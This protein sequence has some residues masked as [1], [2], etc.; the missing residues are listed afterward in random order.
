MIQQ[1]WTW[2]AGVGLAV[3]LLGVLMGLSPAGLALE[4]QFG[5]D[6]LFRVRGPR[7]APPEV[8]VITID[9][10]SAD[11]FQL[12]NE[13]RK[14][15]RHLHAQLV[16]NLTRAGA[17]AVGF[18]IHF[19]ESRDP[20]QD[21]Q[22]AQAIQ[23]A[24]NVVLFEHLQKEAQ[25][26]AG[27]AGEVFG[28]MVAERRIP[29]I[30]S[31][32]QAAVTTAPFPLPKVPVKV[33]QFWLFKGGAGDA[34]TLPTVMFQ[35]YALPIYADLLRIL[36]S[37]T[38]E[39]QALPPDVDTLRRNRDLP[40]VMEQLRWLFQK[41]AIREQ[42]A[43][44]LA[45]DRTLAPR[46]R[47]LLTALLHVYRDQSSRY[48]NYYGP[49]RSLTTLPYHQVW[50]AVGDPVHP[51]P[52][53]HGKLVLVGF[54][55]RLQ[56]E[57][58]DGFYTVYSQEQS[59]LDISGVEIAATALANM[60][61]DH[62]VRPLDSRWMVVLL[63]G[64]GL[65][66]GLAVSA[67]R[68]RWGLSALMIAGVVWFVVAVH[69]FSVQALWLPLMVPLVLQAP[70]AGV[71]AL[72]WRYRALGRERNRIRAAFRHYLPERAVAAL[73]RDLR[74][75]P[76]GELLYG[77][78]LATD[79][80][81]YTGLAERLPPAELAALLNR[82]YEALFA[83]VRR[84]GG[85]VSDVVGDAMLAIWAHA[86]PEVA[87]RAQACQ[88]ALDVAL[89]AEQFRMAPDSGGL[90]TRI[91][92]HAGQ[93]LLGNVGTTDHVEYRAVGDIVNTAS[94]LQDLN[95]IL[96][97][98]VLASRETVDGLDQFLRRDVGVFRLPGKSNPTAVLELRGL[99]GTATDTGRA[100][101]EDFAA[102]R[103]EFSAGRFQEARTGFAHCLERDPEDGPARYYL[104]LTERFLVIPPATG[105]DGILAVS[106]LQSSPVV[107]SS[108][109]H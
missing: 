8:V 109:R 98:R 77:V 102:A 95:K 82:Y 41:P 17:A 86:T 103:R 57:Q 78:C 81:R 72:L 27:S 74:A 14:W 83:P 68:L 39:A 56:P 32:A 25:P 12:P 33:S 18:D 94:R 2:S 42:F 55:E 54:S 90:G 89:A 100:L 85:F 53:L 43:T 70:L 50:Q 92:L 108:N 75:A 79:A 105:W 97:T 37:V 19:A 49:P 48:L 101:L 31:L 104:A 58:K 20:V 38:P 11:Y 61:A 96:G 60:I 88:A 84:H 76:G 65:V 73:A 29:P 35:L 5:L 63:F 67:R 10:E 106:D 34:A 7:P 22:F 9:K 80:A 91:G 16:D 3:G 28:E 30:P 44:H 21:R 71:A 66:A 93:I 99:A 6:G 26:L 59:G 47:Q 46:P 52:E 62:P 45:T 69:V 4:E 87:Q 1:R 40:R 107:T 13:P 15:P 24:G 51:L 23:R 64:W 36:R